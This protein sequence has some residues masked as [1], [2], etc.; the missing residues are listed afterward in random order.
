MTKQRVIVAN[1]GGFWGDDP[2]AARRQVEGGPIDYLVMDYL[3]E[4][5]MAI[6]QKQRA[7]NP[8]AGFPADV[9]VHLR[10]VLPACAERG[11]RII[12]NAG[13]VNPL[14]CRAAIESLAR[15]LG[16]AGRLKVA[17]VLGDDLYPDLDTL[18][19]SGEALINMD[20]GQPLATIRDRVLSANAYVG[21][22]ALVR[23]LELGANVIVAGRVADAAVTL[24]PLIHE[25]GWALNDWDLMAAGVV[26]GHI[27]ECGAQS[28]GGNFTDWHLVKS[29]RNMG[30]P[31]VEVEP[32]GSF[33]VTKH[34]RTGGLVTI[35]TVS[36][37]I[38]YE[39]G[40]PAYVSPDVVARFD[41]I[42]LEQEAPD[43]VRVTGARGEPAPAKLKVSV[44]YHAGWR[45][46]GRLIL[47]GPDALAKA[48]K[49][50]EAFWESAGGRGL[51]ERAIHQ[52]IGWNGC[53][54]PLAASEPGEVLV[55][56]A[57]RDRDERKIN[58]RF[59]TQIVPRVLG[60]VPGIS[61]I[62]DQGRPRASEVVAFWP[63]LVSR[64][65]VSQRVVIGDDETAVGEPAAL[66]PSRSAAPGPGPELPR[67]GHA[68]PRSFPE[69]T[70][71]VRLLK[72]CLARSGD[73]GDTANIGVIARSEAI[74]RWMIDNLTA[75][76]VKRHFDGVCEG[77]VERHELPNLW[78][79][80]FLLH[81]SLG[82]GGAASLLV[83]AQG[84]T[85]AQYLLAAEVE[86]SEGLIARDEAART[87][88]T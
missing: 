70:V 69:R 84:K 2:A 53:H 50:A 37:Q 45:A 4:V 14:G 81:R 54:P 71:R 56:F 67:A 76:F 86:V 36:E 83:D 60:T 9:L 75:G 80:N 17:A 25:F 41:A 22:A 15:D 30:F 7:R 5:T 33:V 11:I 66:T 32:D 12:T 87:T 35:H 1:C 29:F 42:A 51:Y 47:S 77:E 82:G 24:A 61:Y 62:A 57:V 8:D 21:A 40:S 39:I 27:I 46:F 16:L 79:V 55:Q 3:A 26:A 72:L 48:S 13:G 19:G 64:S 49:V 44:S 34:P 31:L 73:K 63:A 68:L 74:Y 58:T 38:L 6:L 88:A 18:L 52:F 85:Y 78:A 10:D 59:A 65:A 43:R 20:T 28:T 23:A